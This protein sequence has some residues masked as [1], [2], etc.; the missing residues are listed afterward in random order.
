MRKIAVVVCLVACMG[1]VG[2]SRVQ[3][4]AALGAGVGAIPGAIIGSTSAEAGAGAL[5]GAG[6]GA[7]V[8]ALVGDGLQ[9]V[10]TKKEIDELNNQLKAKEEMLRKEQADKDKLQAEIDALNKQIADLQKPRIRTLGEVKTPY[11]GLEVRETERGMECTIVGK[12]MFKSGSA[13]LTKEGTEAVTKLAAYIRT[14]YP[15]KKLS[16]QGH[17]DNEPIRHSGW[18]SNRELACARSLTVVTFLVAKQGF[19][20]QGVHSASFGEYRPVAPNDTKEGRAQ[21]RRA[22]VTVL[23]N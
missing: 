13:K 23:N 9:Q 19:D 14:E 22:T 12:A 17:T 11:E 20:P 18:K 4:G 5:V 7:L 6:A 2:C 15:G 1:L 8:G 10:E 3:Q 21:N 16:V